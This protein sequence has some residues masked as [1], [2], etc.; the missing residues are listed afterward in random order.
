MP[1]FLLQ[2]I[3]YLACA[4]LNRGVGGEFPHT[5]RARKVSVAVLFD[6]AQRSRYTHHDHTSSRFR[7]RDIILTQGGLRAEPLI[8]TEQGIYSS[9]REHIP[10]FSS[11]SCK[12]RLRDVRLLG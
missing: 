7:D 10:R 3:F 4:P 6:G 8:G 11:N 5:S 12:T 9:I 1:I 2:N